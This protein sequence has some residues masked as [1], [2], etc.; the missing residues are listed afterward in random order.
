MGDARHFLVNRDTPETPRIT[1]DLSFL[2]YSRH[3]RGTPRGTPRSPR[4]QYTPRTTPRS[5]RTGGERESVRGIRAELLGY[6]NNNNNTS[7]SHDSPRSPTT[8]RSSRRS[9]AASPVVRRTGADL[10]A[11]SRQRR[12]DSRF[13]EKSQL[14]GLGQSRRTPCG[15][16]PG[17]A[18]EVRH[19][20]AEAVDKTPRQEE[21]P[22]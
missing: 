15:L 14:I 20:M 3:N 8:P 17:A 6:N 13:G 5:S 22:E 10:R 4:D 12:G 9:L 21:V 18:V 16:T 11:R 2:S 7:S 1:P 19:S